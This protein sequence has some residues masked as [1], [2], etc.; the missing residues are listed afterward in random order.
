MKKAAYDKNLM[1]IAIIIKKWKIG[2]KQDI[3][4]D[5]RQASADETL[6]YR[7]AILKIYMKNT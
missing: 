6:F 2:S 5:R 7:S 3:N 1:S 4:I